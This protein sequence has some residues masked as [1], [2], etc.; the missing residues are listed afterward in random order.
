M[1][2]TITEGPHTDENIQKCYRYILQKYL[3]QVKKEEQEQ[4]QEQKKK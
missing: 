4:E 1:K 2:V 3:Q